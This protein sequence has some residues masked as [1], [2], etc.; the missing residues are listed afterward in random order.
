[1]Y[2][3]LPTT[4]TTLERL[5]ANLDGDL[6]LPGEDGWDEARTAWNLALDQQPVAVVVAES[7]ADVAETVRVARSA[8]LRVAPQGTGHGGSSLGDLAETILLRTTRMRGA[9][10]DPAAQTARVEAGVLWQEVTD[11][12]AEHGLAALAGS[13]HDVG[14]FGYTLG[15]GVSWLARKHGL[16]ANSVVAAEIVDAEGVE[17]R[18]DHENDPDLFWAI[19]GGGGAFAIVTALEL[20]LFPIT[21][22]YA[23]TLFFPIDGAREVLAAWLELTDRAPEELMSVG[24]LM[25]FP[26]FPFVPESVRGKEFALVEVTYLGDEA[27]GIELT[28]PLRELGP[29]LDTTGMIPA[30]RLSELH[31]DPP[32]PVPGIGDGRM[33]E[34]LS[35]EAVDAIVESAGADSGSSLLSVEVRHL[36]GALGRTSPGDGA[37]YLDSAYVMF[38]VG[39]AAGPEAAAR[40]QHDVERVIRA[41]EPWDSGRDYLNFRES[42]S[43]GERLFSAERYARLAAI[44]ATVDPDNVFRSNHEV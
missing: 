20:R 19:R 23:G 9:S 10:V 7:P 26:D 29:V 24:R 32:S 36:G 39:I 22:V 34:P 30:R 13:S 14:V 17:R 43:T 15:G 16:S 21:E 27:D 25:R 18:I 33:L 6:V 37:A 5:R 41:I 40:T 3:L 12:A 8:G 31:M 44:K 11:A 4:E 2:T 28:R 42:E 1:V 35:L 38:A